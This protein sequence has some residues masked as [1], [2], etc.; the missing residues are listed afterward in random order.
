MC[1]SVEFAQFETG[2]MT[3]AGLPTTNTDAL[4]LYNRLLNV[5]YFFTRIDYI[6]VTGYTV[7][8]TWTISFDERKYAKKIETAVEGCSVLNG[9]KAVNI[10]HKINIIYKV[11][12]HLSKEKTF[13]VHVYLRM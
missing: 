3:A 8:S 1:T 12:A 6:R 10:F 2:L 9:Q 4:V 13:L 7:M 11:T 5:R